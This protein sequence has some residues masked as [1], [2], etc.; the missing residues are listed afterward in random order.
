MKKVVVSVV[1][2]CLVLLLWNPVGATTHHVYPGPGTPI[3]DAINGASPGDTIIVHPGTY[4]DNIT[5]SK[6]TITLISASGPTVTII[7]Y[8]G[9]WCGYWSTGN[10][11]VDIPYG[12]S[13]VCVQGFTIRGGSPA[14]DALISIGGDDNIIRGNII[15]GDP[16]S[17]GQDI[18]IHIGD[19]SQETPSYPS[20]NQVMDN[21]VYDHA[22]A[23]IFVGNWAGSGNV[24][25]GNRVHDNVVGSI[26]GLNGN[27]IELDR[28]LGVRVIQNVVFNNEAAGIKVIRTAPG[29][30]IDIYRNTLFANQNGIHSERWRTGATTS[31]VV[32]ATCNNI[33][34]NSQYG[35][36]N[37]ESATITAPHNWW[38][39][40]SGPFHSTANPPGTGNQVSGFV[41]FIPWGHFPDP[42]G[43]R[44]TGTESTQILRRELCP[45]ARANVEAAEEMLEGV[46]EV[47]ELLGP[48]GDEDALDDPYGEALALIAEAQALIERAKLYCLNSQNC[49]PGNTLAIEALEL[50]E[51]ANELLGTLLG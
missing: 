43:P 25:S 7:D 38:G 27:G 20:S 23:G 41:A 46:Q 37:D 21:E 14:S 16:V 9:V 34:N 4:F 36:R 48:V 50:L 5:L 8:T 3:Q 40:T 42:C 45:L 1:C 26:P 13:G 2:G 30:T 44:M 12:V 33:V 11:G 28:V 31:A 22:G 15:V 51:K 49:V 6:N 17:S 24:I 10:G 32:T 47:L 19:V 35:I 29:A 18:G 39:H